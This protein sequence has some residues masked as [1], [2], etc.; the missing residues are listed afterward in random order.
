MD[1]HPPIE[2]RTTKQLL[3]IIE[4]KDQWRDEVVQLTKVELIKRGIPVL[5]QERRWNSSNKYRK[6]IQSIKSRATYTTFEK[7]LI[8]LIGPLLALILRDI[9]M[10][11][12]GDGFKRKNQQGLFYLLLGIG[13]WV[14]IIYL[15]YS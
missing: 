2:N 13:L 5:T 8:V 15:I 14:L 9:F 4:S 3:E 12:P 1:I 7:I 10:F 11:Q 6:R